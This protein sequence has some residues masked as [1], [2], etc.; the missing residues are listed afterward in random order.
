MHHCLSCSS[1]VDL[2]MP[3][4]NFR[5]L[6]SLQGVVFLGVSAVPKTSGVNIKFKIGLCTQMHFKSGVKVSY[7]IH[8]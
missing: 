3:Q 4:Q 8:M 2:H 5:K 7:C 6:I 1:L